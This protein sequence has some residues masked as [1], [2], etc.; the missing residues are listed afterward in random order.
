MT[1][2]MPENVTTLGED[3]TPMAEEGHNSPIPPAATPP[4]PPA[5]PAIY[6]A[7]S[8]VQKA[9][10][11]IGVSKA[12]QGP[13]YKFRGIEDVYEVAA[14]TMPRCGLI[15]LPSYGS[16]QLSAYTSKQGTAMTHVYVRCDMRFYAV[17]DGSSVVS[18][19]YGEAS[20]TGDKAIN[21]AMSDAQK[22]A[23]FQTFWVP[24]AGVEDPDAEKSEG[25]PIP[26]NVTP[27]PRE[28]HNF[29]Q[30]RHDSSTGEVRS[31]AD[32]V[33]SHVLHQR[34]EREKALDAIRNEFGSSAVVTE[35]APPEPVDT[36][37]VAFDK[38]RQT[39][40]GCASCDDVERV[41]ATNKRLMDALREQRPE[42][43][44]RIMQ[45]AQ[46]RKDML[47]GGKRA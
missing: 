17:A 41:V 14:M 9:I 42:S 34:Y 32:S 47:S 29:P 31:M 15:G 26:A 30:P 25:G 20:D 27:Q 44:K 18:T 37:K 16:P 45:I 46:S 19:V 8:E 10:A 36:L 11:S 28:G 21:K 5:V 39:I 38:M 33:S 3:V 43:Y 13:G 2:A 35:E 23:F 40:A 24:Y 4:S 6:K 22:Y 12:R 7:I 1:D